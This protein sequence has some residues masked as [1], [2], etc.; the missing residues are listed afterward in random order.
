MKNSVMII[1]DD[2]SNKV[3]LEINCKHDEMTISLIG[4]LCKQLI[5]NNVTS[6]DKLIKFLK[7][8]L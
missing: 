8:I 6:K 4:I 2:E 3:D 1:F 5:K 7:I